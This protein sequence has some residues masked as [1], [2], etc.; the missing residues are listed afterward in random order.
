MTEM[1][2]LRG[3]LR[4]NIF[5]LQ[6][7]VTRIIKVT[8]SRMIIIVSRLTLQELTNRQQTCNKTNIQQTFNNIQQNST[9]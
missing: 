5:K 6:D 8:R 3:A 1:G 2:Q 9:L 7:Q 4:Y